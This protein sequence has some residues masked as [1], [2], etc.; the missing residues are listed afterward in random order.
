V[1]PKRIPVRNQ[2]RAIGIETE[3]HAGLASTRLQLEALRIRKDHARREIVP[4]ATEIERIGDNV[5]C[6]LGHSGARHQTNHDRVTGNQR[7]FESQT[8][9][10]RICGNDG[11]RDLAGGIFEIHRCAVDQ[12]GH[13][14]C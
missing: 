5:G 2:P 12:D 13:S 9:L 8:H 11:S 10:I 7:G 3:Q 1:P 6:H 14:A 4:D